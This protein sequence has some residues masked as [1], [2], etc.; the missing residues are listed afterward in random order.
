MGSFFWPRG[1]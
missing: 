1:H